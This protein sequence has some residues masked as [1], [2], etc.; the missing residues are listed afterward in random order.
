VNWWKV[1]RNGQSLY[2]DHDKSRTD[3]ALAQW[4]QHG[5][6]DVARAAMHRTKIHASITVDHLG[7]KPSKMKLIPTGQKACGYTLLYMEGA[8]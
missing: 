2:W 1:T 3:D 7:D 5:P 6:W 4:R 8:L